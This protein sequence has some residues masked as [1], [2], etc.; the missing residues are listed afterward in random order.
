MDWM[1]WD[2]TTDLLF[3]GVSVDRWF[4]VFE[5]AWAVFNMNIYKS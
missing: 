2:V 1:V 4:C 3:W 5:G